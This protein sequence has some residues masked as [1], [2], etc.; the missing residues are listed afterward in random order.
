M[1]RKKYELVRGP[2]PTDRRF[3]D[4][5]GNRFGRL[6]VTGFAGRQGKS[7]VWN[8]ACDCG[9][10][11]AVH[12]VSLRSGGTASCGCLVA[13]A[14]RVTNT[15]HGLRSHPLYHIWRQM[16]ARCER[17]GHARFEGYGGRGIRVCK[18]FQDVG[19]YV[20]YVEETLGPKPSP[21][22]TIDRADNERGYERGNLRWAL[23]EKQN[24][25]RRN[26]V[27][28][29][30][31]GSR[32]PLLEAC[33]IFGLRYYT[34]YARLCRYGWAE[35]DALVAPL[36]G[37]RPPA[38]VAQSPW[39]RHGP[40]HELAYALFGAREPAQLPGVPTTTEVHQNGK[41]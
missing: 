38:V 12:G 15:V 16:V 9:C 20:R 1:A 2:K 32:V 3:V 5:T 4:L 37:K 23:P 24:L 41:K 31:C 11:S 30:L 39:T 26:T 18:E 21:E 7:F 35:A 10:T 13:D 19:A 14:A 33:E 17:P 6:V 34:A 22:H 28:V 36:G 29:T 8:C 40:A 27:A 25:N